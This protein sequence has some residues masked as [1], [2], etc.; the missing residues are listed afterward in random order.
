MT[1]FTSR[2]S[3]VSLRGNAISVPQRVGSLFRDRPFFKS[4][5]LLAGGTAAAQAI[6]ILSTPLVTR[7]YPPEHFGVLAV[8]VSILGIT[9]PLATLRYAVTIPIAE[10]EELADNVLRLCFLVTLV[11]SLLFA[12]GLGFFGSTISQRYPDNDASRYFWLLPVCLF[13]TGL[14]QA[15]SGWGLRTKQFKLIARTSLSQ[16]V[17]SAST[18]IGLGV[19]GVRPLGLLLGYFMSQAAGLGCILRALIRQKPRFFREGSW[20][21][22][23]YAAR[24]FA[25]FPLLQGWSQ[26]LLG[27]GIQLPVLLVA[28]LYG[29]KAAG[30]FGLAFN[31]VNMPMNIL[32]QS[33]GQVYFAEIAQYGK[34]RPDKILALSLSVAKKLLLIAAGPLAVIAILGPLLFGLVFGQEWGEAGIYARLLS[35]YI[36]S[37]FVTAPIAQC[38]NVLEMQVLQILVNVLRVAVLLAAFMACKAMMLNSHQAVLVFSLSASAFRVSIMVLL[39][40]VLTREA[41]KRRNACCCSPPL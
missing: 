15:L 21:G 41:F 27:L 12:L 34:S 32:G 25:R 22:M 28:A 10:D 6:G 13:T 19:F 24:R 23:G 33:V 18:K 37:G 29:A 39:F 20:R 1:R 30:F 11:L 2:A 3:R 14:Y 35:I 16:G 38:L 9:T 5:A 7:L 36:L 31:M 8:F 26:F 17:S 4:V 40:R